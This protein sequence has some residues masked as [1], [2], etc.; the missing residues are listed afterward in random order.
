MN[1]LLSS[2][3]CLSPHLESFASVSLK[4][5]LD[6]LQLPFNLGSSLTPLPCRLFVLLFH[7]LTLWYSGE[8]E[9]PW[10][11]VLHCTSAFFSFRVFFFLVRSLGKTS[12]WEG[13]LQNPYTSHSSRRDC[14]CCICYGCLRKHCELQPSCF[15]S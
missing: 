10:N 13:Y 6:F 12:A 14:S 7:C 9:S 11:I 1:F 8:A 2:L 4:P 3:V 15:P 5:C